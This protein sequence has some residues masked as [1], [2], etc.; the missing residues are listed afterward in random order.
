VDGLPIPSSSRTL[1]RELSENLG[2][3][4]VKCCSYVLRPFEGLRPEKV[5]SCRRRHGGGLSWG[6]LPFGVLCALDQQAIGLPAPT[7]LSHFWWA[8]RFFFERRSPSP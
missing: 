4:F 1:I 7:G 8:R 6:C 2:G 3:G 5:S